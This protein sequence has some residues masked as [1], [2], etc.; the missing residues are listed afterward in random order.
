M[1]NFVS[2]TADFLNIIKEMITVGLNVNEIGKIV[3]LRL[4]STLDQITFG[5]HHQ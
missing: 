5:T 3:L 1:P 4:C 2:T